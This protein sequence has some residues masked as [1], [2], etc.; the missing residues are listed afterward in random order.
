MKTIFIVLSLFNCL[1]SQ[2]IIN[3]IMFNPNGNE[4]HTEFVEIYNKGNNPIDLTNFTI[5][6]QDEQD[7]ILPYNENFTNILPP[8]SYGIILDS[9]YEENSTYYEDLIPTGVCRFVIDDGSFG[10]YGFS[11]SV[12]ET[13]ILKDNN[14]NTIDEVTY[15]ID[16]NP[17]FSDERIMIDQN[18]WSNSLYERGTPGFRNSST[19]L[20]RDLMIKPIDN[21]IYLDGEAGFTVSIE[22]RGVSAIEQFTLT[23]KLGSEV[24]YSVDNSSP[25]AP[26]SVVDF[27]IDQLNLDYGYNKLS[28]I[29]ECEDDLNLSNNQ[30]NVE[31][32]RKFGKSSIVLNEFMK[33]PSENSCEWIEIYNLS[34]N[35]FNIKYLSV[36]DLTSQVVVKDSVE[37]EPNDY[38]VFAKDSSIISFYGEIENIIISKQFPALSSDDNLIIKDPE[39][40]VLDSFYYKNIWN[41]EYDRSIEKINPKL[42][43]QSSSSWAVSIEKGTP[44][45]RNS[46]YTEIGNNS[47]KNS[48]KLKSKV[49]TP[50]GDGKKDNF[51]IEYNFEKPFINLSIDIFNIKGQ[52]IHTLC[53]ESY[54]NS[55]GTYIWNCKRKNRKLKLGSYL[56]FIKVKSGDF[57]KDYKKPFYIGKK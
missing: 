14:S 18:L 5:G 50:N 19:P 21:L 10:K 44:S 7:N 8:M 51:I 17:G 56:A 35:S 54:Q 15:T 52:K 48:L 24:L 43:S 2:I 47:S 13:V 30:I 49:I 37:L 27:E 33:S 34:N 23:V 12:E 39:N 22:N 25:L 1:Y 20:D 41:E 42:Q 11:N 16:Q 38:F 9:S 26:N 28:L 46:V 57:E 3:E 6:D 40:V 4:Y 32:F 29:L 55:S 53:K 31:T 36:G 45:K